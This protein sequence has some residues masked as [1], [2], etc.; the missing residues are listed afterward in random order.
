[1]PLE[2]KDMMN[3][4]E[5]LARMWRA[6]GHPTVTAVKV[7]EKIQG[8]MSQDNRTATVVY[9]DGHEEK[10]FIKGCIDKP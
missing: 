3:N 9:E 2:F 6:D 8:G 10:V 4:E 5:L 7:A 1:M